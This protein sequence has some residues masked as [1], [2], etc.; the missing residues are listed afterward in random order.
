MYITNNKIPSPFTKG[1]T[2]N[3]IIMSI[4]TKITHW[5]CWTLF[6]PW[7]SRVRNKTNSLPLSHACEPCGQTDKHCVHTDRLRARV[8]MTLPLSSHHIASLSKPAPR[9]ISIKG[10]V[11]PVSCHFLETSQVFLEVKGARL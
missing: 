1:P 6:F 4:L 11:G 3:N 7:I 2:I 10:P 8:K 5:N 9:S